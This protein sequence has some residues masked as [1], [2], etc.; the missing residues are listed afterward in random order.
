MGIIFHLSSISFSYI[1][2]LF[3]PIAFNI[4]YLSFIFSG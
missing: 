4:T 1:Y 2:P 3:K